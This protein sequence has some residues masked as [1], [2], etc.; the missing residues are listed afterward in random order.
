MKEEIKLLLDLMY[1]KK[2]DDIADE[3]VEYSIKEWETVQD[4]NL[5]EAFISKKNFIKLIFEEKSKIKALCQQN[6][7]NKHNNAVSLDLIK[8]LIEE[9][10]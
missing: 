3:E 10:K 5:K 1:D 2:K 6:N 4:Q 9:K 8:I 7:M